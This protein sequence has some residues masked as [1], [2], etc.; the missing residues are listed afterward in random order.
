MNNLKWIKD[1]IDNEAELLA[2]NSLFDE[3][4]K[5]ANKIKDLCYR[6]VKMTREIYERSDHEIQNK[7]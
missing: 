5:R 1:Y 7:E 2:N 6:V 3:N 4:E